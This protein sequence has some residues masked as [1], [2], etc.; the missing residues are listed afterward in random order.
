MQGSNI[1]LLIKKIIFVNR[2]FLILIFIFAFLP[3]TFY[4][5]LT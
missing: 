2:I 4:H 1:Y 3:V 5:P